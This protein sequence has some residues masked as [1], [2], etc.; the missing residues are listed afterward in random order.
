MLLILC[1][2]LAVYD[3]MRVVVI[4]APPANAA[5]LD[6]RIAD[7]RRSILFSHHADYAAATVA[8]HPGQVIKAFDGATHYLLDARLMMAWAKAL[9]ES[10]ETDKARY[11]A[12]RLKEFHN[13]QADAFFAP[14]ASKATS[15]AAPAASAPASA[16]AERAVP[17]PCA[18]PPAQLRGFSLAAFERATPIARFAAALFQHP[19][20]ADDHAAIDRLAHVVD[21][22]QPDLHGSQ[23][24]HLDAGAAEAFPLAQCSAPRSPRE[25]SRTRRRC[26]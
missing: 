24:F 11:V 3:Y 16:A 14:C 13:E 15:W 26:A 7:G 12:Q 5:P 21:G 8:E 10:G 2:T 17:V 23:R 6:K 4:F 20:I 19:D 25:R 18:D 22:Q 1:G 9:D